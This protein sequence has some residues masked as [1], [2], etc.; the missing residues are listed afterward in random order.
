MR[1]SQFWQHRAGWERGIDGTSNICELLINVVMQNKPKG[2]EG[3]DQKVRGMV[4]A[5]LYRFTQSMIPSA[6]RQ[7]LTHLMELTEHGKP[8]CLHLKVESDP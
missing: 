7:A 8:N 1:G 3:L 5:L 6:E 2:L 4:K